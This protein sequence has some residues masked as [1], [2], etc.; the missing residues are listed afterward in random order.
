MTAMKETAKKTEVKEVKEVKKTRNESMKVPK[1]TTTKETPKKN[2]NIS[3]AESI[4][5]KTIKNAEVKEIKKETTQVPKATTKKEVEKETTKEKSFEKRPSAGK[6]IREM[7]ESIIP[8]L[9]KEH[10]EILTSAEKTKETLKI[11]YSFLKEATENKED[12][13]V[14]GNAR[15]GSKTI[16]INN[17]SY[18]I[19]NDLYNRNIET[20]EKWIKTIK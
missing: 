12:R 3:K 5:K 18:W 19:T 2:E 15:Y 6:Q 17:K 13:K 10:L 20:F 16:T 14:N 8:K 9:T 7:F 4:S 1:E 11:R